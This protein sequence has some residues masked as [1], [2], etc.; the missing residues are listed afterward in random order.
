MFFISYI[1][2]FFVP[3]SDYGIGSP[4]PVRSFIDALEASSG[5]RNTVAFVNN[6]HTGGDIEALINYLSVSVRTAGKIP[7]VLANDQALLTTC[8]SSLRGASQCFG[9]ASFHSSPTEAGNVWNY[10][11]RADG[12]LGSKIYVNRNDNDAETYILPF[13]HAIDVA[14]VNQF[15]GSANGTTFPSIVNE[16]PFTDK[17]QQQRADDI[18]RLY[19]NAVINF[20]GVAYFIGI[21]GIIYQS[22]GHMASER[23][24]GMSQLIEAVRSTIFHTFILEIRNFSRVKFLGVPQCFFWAYSCRT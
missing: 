17:T 7:V 11:L 20:L 14:I 13:Q 3:P 5:G 1:K 10:T 8:R 24:L 4:T 21:C 23:E 9:A 6:G 19:M 12:A 22:T 16:F 15:N 18:R 2:N